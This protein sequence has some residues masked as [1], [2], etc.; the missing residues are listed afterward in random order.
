MLGY[1]AKTSSD[2]CWFLKKAPHFGSKGDASQV[3]YRMLQYR[4]SSI[5]SSFSFL[6]GLLEE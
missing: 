3:A 4:F 1:F 5:D 6:V 2:P